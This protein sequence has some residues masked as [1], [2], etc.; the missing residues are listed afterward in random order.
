[1]AESPEQPCPLQEKTLRGI[2]WAIAAA[3]HNLPW[4]S[5]C[6]VRALAAKWML[7]RRQIPSTFYLGVATS[8][9]Q[10]FEAHAWVR[11]GTFILTGGPGHLRHRVIARFSEWQR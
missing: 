1:M 6:L 9:R 3:S 10:S 5:R 4:T 2:R 11:C 8:E 7:R